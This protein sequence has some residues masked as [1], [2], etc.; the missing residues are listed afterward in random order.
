MDDD[1]ILELPPADELK[2]AV[3]SDA[4]QLEMQARPVKI[5]I[6]GKLLT[7]LRILYQRPA[8]FYSRLLASKQTPVNQVLGDRIL[9]L[10]SLI[11]IQQQQIAELRARLPREDE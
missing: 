5:P 2:N 4:I 8:L 7:K 9:Q 3:K 6:I 1:Y 11:K 10:E